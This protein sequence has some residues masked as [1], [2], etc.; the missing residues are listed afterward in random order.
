VH[1][2]AAISILCE[3]PKWYEKVRELSLGKQAAIVDMAST[4]NTLCLGREDGVRLSGHIGRIDS[5]GGS[6]TLVV[7]GSGEEMATAVVIEPEQIDFGTPLRRTGLPGAE[8]RSAFIF[9]EGL[10]QESVL[11]PAH[12]WRA[13]LVFRIGVAAILCG[14]AAVAHEQAVAY[15]AQRKQF[16]APLLALPAVHSM[17]SKNGDLLRRCVQDVLEVAARSDLGESASYAS[18]AMLGAVS[19]ASILIA[20][21]SLQIHGGYGYLREYNIEGHL[22][23]VLSLC[24]ASGAQETQDE[25]VLRFDSLAA[26]SE[27]LP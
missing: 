25:A 17:V 10:S 24:A 2:Q 23:N 16:G 13:R 3:H 26:H 1:T 8:T 19:Q 14:I 4:S 22:R 11:A 6:P 12:C 9:D 5:A 27:K 18:A 15:A 7:M 20:D 21:G